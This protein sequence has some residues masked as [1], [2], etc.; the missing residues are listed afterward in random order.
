MI[1]RTTIS[2]SLPAHLA[3][4][5]ETGLEPA[6]RLE[7]LLVLVTL[8]EGER[9]GDGS[10]RLILASDKGGLA[11]GILEV[12]LAQRL[13]VVGGGSHVAPQEPERTLVCGVGSSQGGVRDSDAGERGAAA[14]GEV[15][16]RTKAAAAGKS[17]LG[18]E[19]AGP[20]SSETS[21]ERDFTGTKRF[22]QRGSRGGH[23]GATDRKKTP[24]SA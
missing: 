19:A 4:Q 23:T 22:S 8:T 2:M 12:L 24:P 3:S 14:A 10:T 17:L 5:D 6:E 11:G 21:S 13:L 15:S 7:V 18:L 20:S 1:P 9:I 16:R